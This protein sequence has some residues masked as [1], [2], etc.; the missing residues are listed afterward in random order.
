MAQ[1]FRNSGE[2][3]EAEAHLV[4]ASNISG[5]ATIETQYELLLE[6]ARYHLLVEN[7]SLFDRVVTLMERV[8]E[9]LGA[10]QDRPI[11]WVQYLAL[12]AHN[13]RISG[14]ASDTKAKSRT[15]FSLLHTFS[16]SVREKLYVVTQAADLAPYMSKLP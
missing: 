16:R 9:A 7:G 12:D 15:F 4:Q 1:F 14:R 11:A 8:V 13:A 10:T 3:K 2:W 5:E 6:T